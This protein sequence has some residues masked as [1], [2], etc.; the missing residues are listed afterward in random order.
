MTLTWQGYGSLV[1]RTD[2]AHPAEWDAIQAAIT[3]PQTPDGF[4]PSVRFV[5]DD[6]YDGLSASQLVEMAPMHAAIIAFL[7]DGQTLSHPDRPVLVVNVWQ[8][9]GRTFRVI[10]SE[11]WSVENNLSQSN[12][13]W[14]DFADSVDEDGIFRGFGRQGAGT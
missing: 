3:E 5:D 1:I 10:P 2:F 9:N 11:M 7:V 12:M 13:D 14:K 4:L 8:R 6:R